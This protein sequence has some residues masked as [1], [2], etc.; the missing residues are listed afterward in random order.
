MERKKLIITLLAAAIL[1]VVLILGI[2]I[3]FKITQKAVSPVSNIKP[4][5]S[6][7]EELTTWSDPAE[8]SFRYPKSLT[9]DPHDEDKKNYAH[10]ELT[11]A[12][13]PGNLI[14]WVKDTAAKDIEDWVK[15]T[16]L[17]GA[18][19]STLGGEAAKK[20][21]T[22]D[23]PRS[24]TTTVIYGGYLYQIEVNLTDFDFWNKIY[25]TVSSSFKFVPAKEETSKEA[26]PEQGTQ[27]QNTGE[28]EF[29]EEEVIE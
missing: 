21:L 16:K 12:T 29:T 3:R 1:L 17:Q 24:M 9:V 8:F 7:V 25:E 14:V 27:D 28:E 2:Y 13:H 6:A 10:V 23:E 19:D 15:Q 18:I 4:T 11:S 5:L 26:I 22:T 20:V